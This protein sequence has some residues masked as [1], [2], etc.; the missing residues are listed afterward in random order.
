[1]AGTSGTA[2]SGA[3]GTTGG[4]GGNGG[5]GGSGG[6]PIGTGGAGIGGNGGQG[7]AGGAGGG[8][9]GAR[10]ATGAGGTGRD[11]GCSGRIR[12]RKNS[13]GWFMGS[14]GAQAC[15]PSRD[16]EVQYRPPT[17]P[18][19]SA[20]ERANSAEPRASNRHRDIRRR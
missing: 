6:N 18:R 8:G 16:A 15:R 7:G 1:T 12:F 9:C 2:G 13:G 14:S 3:A 19:Q 11:A 5:Q 10:S 4:Q 17:G 20:P